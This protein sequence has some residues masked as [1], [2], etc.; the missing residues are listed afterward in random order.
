MLQ[1]VA[2]RPHRGPQYWALAA[3]LVPLV[4]CGAH[5]QQQLEDAQ[6]T[7][8]VKTVILN[9]ATVGAEAIL[10]DAVDGI[11]TL[12]GTV[13]TAELSDRAE[14]IARAVEGVR[15]V[16]LDLAVATTPAAPDRP[17]RRRAV[18]ART[19]GAAMPDEPSPP[20]VGVGAALDVHGPRDESLGRTVAV[21]PVFLW[22]R[23][24]GLG[25][26]F[27]LGWF[28]TE[29]T[30]IEN[31]GEPAGTLRVRPVMGGVGY[32]IV[33]GPTWMKTSILAGVS[34]N[35]LSTSEAALAPTRAIGISRSFAWRSGVQV[36]YF[37]SR[38][39]SVD[40]SLSY[41][42]TR[43]D[44]TFLGP[45]GIETRAIRADALQLRASLV[46]WPF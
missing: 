32:T 30:P 6:L 19:G 1:L 43:P 39:V 38:R 2:D 36:G 8:R 16:R 29:I 25:P 14:L 15:S 11:V 18:A 7:V 37:V 35:S 23:S 3:C 27:G 12:S 9:D 21:R 33:R 42:V 34:F 4:A 24:A 41:V 22:R 5:V 28:P 40:G 46:Y 26:A 31:V 45:D 13:R 44:V 20:L 10:V 17:P